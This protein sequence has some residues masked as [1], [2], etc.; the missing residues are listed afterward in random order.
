MNKPLYL[1][2]LLC[3]LYNN[4][5]TSDYDTGTRHPSQ[6]AHDYDDGHNHEGEI[7]ANKDKYQDAKV[8]AGAAGNRWIWQKGKYWQILEQDLMVIL[9]L[10]LYTRRK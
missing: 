9:L 10:E 5:C 8:N 6:H 3:F 2:V 4:S 7:K 1:L